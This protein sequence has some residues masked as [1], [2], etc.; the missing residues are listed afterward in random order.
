M[1]NIIIF[2]NLIKSLYTNL[3]SS[4]LQNENY[5]NGSGL[6]IRMNIKVSTKTLPKSITNN[7]IFKNKIKNL[8]EAPQSTPGV[9][10]FN[11][12]KMVKENTFI[13]QI[14]KEDFLGLNQI[15]AYQNPFYKRSDINDY[16]KSANFKNFVDSQNQMCEHPAIYVIIGRV[17]DYTIIGRSGLSTKMI[18]LYE[19]VTGLTVS[20]TKVPLE[21]DQVFYNSIVY[22]KVPNENLELVLKYLNDNP[23]VL[24]GG[25]K[26]VEI[27]KDVY[28]LEQLG[29][30]FL[31]YGDRLDLD[32]AKW[33]SANGI[34]RLE[35]L[36]TYKKDEE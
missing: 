9:I 10:D 26:S 29:V 18:P 22:F 6:N 35:N 19:P 24:K 34:K 11:Q 27:I 28:I 31:R 13:N 30:I 5:N 1:K 21:Y 3:Y 33:A 15:T 16:L 32:M 7:P 12:I 17:G 8:P 2:V 25:L 36:I 23:N 4:N 20:Y 14:E